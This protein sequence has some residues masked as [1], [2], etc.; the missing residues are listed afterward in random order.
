MSGAKSQN[1]EED[2]DGKDE[3]WVVAL[4]ETLDEIF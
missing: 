3:A 1:K 2:C 4:P